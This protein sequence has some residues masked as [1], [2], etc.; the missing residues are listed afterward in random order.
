LNN[1]K[2]IKSLLVILLLS[3]QLLIT[4][5]ISNNPD[6]DYIEFQNVN[7]TYITKYFDIYSSKANIS[8]KST[9]FEKVLTSE[10]LFSENFYT[11]VL[12]IAEKLGFL[13]FINSKNNQNYFLTVITE[14][15]VPRSPPLI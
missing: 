5:L 11:K 13:F 9:P 1:Y 4:S 7:E 12:A 6:R 10:K 8:N 2:K 3:T 15:T 14:A